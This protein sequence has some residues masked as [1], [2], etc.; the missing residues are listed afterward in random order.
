VVSAVRFLRSSSPDRV[1]HGQIHDV[2][3]AGLRLVL[4]EPVTAGESLLVEILG[5]QTI[6]FSLS[7]QVAWCTPEDSRHR[8]GCVLVKPLAPRHM[9]RLRTLLQSER[10]P[11]AGV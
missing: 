4:E 9:A 8:V 2:S 3:T 6:L 10:R 5:E 11:L 1:L 7:T